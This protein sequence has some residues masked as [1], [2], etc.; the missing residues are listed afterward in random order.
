MEEYK[1]KY[2]NAVKGINTDSSENYQPD[3]TYRFALNV[4]N[5][6]EKDNEPFLSNENSNINVIDIPNIEVLGNIYVGDNENILFIVDIVTL[7][8][9]I[10][11]IKDNIVT[12]IIPLCSELHL[13]RFHRVT[14][15]F[16]KIRGCEK[17]IYF[18]DNYNKP[19]QLN[20]STLENYF[21]NNVLVSDRLNL[22]DDFSFPSFDIKVID[23]P[24]KLYAGSYSI[25][26]QYL[27]DDFNS[28]HWIHISNPVNVYNASTTTK[29]PKIIGSYTQQRKDSTYDALFS[30]AMCRK[31]IKIKINHTANN[32]KVFTYFR[33][34]IIIARADTGNITEVLASPT[35]SIIENEIIY[36]GNNEGYYKITKEE[37]LTEKVDIDTVKHIEQYDNRL[38][39]ANGKG[40][41]IDWCSFQKTASKIRSDYIIDT[42]KAHDVNTSNNPKSS[43]SIKM[44]FMGGDVYAFGIVYIFNDGTQSPTYH[45]PGKSS[46]GDS[47][48]EFYEVTSNV[49]E[50][51]PIASNADYWGQ[52]YWGNNLTGQK[53]RHHKFPDR[54]T[55]KLTNPYSGTG[56]K[57]FKFSVHLTFNETPS[58]FPIT[59]VITYFKNGI[60]LQK[61]ISLLL[62]EYSSSLLVFIDYGNITDDFILGAVSIELHDESSFTNFTT[63]SSIDSIDDPLYD[64][65]LNL[66]TI[67][68]SNIIYPSSD[69][70][71]HF[72]V[73]AKRDSNNRLIIDK[74]IV[75]SLNIDSNLPDKNKYITNFYF[76]NSQTYLNKD[77][78]IFY[79]KSPKILFN[80]D[81]LNPDSIKIEGAYRRNLSTYNDTLQ[82]NA[83]PGTSS[84]G[85]FFG[86]IKGD[87]DGM[88]WN[89][90]SKY[91]NYNFIRFDDL[92][93]S[94][95]L[96]E[97]QGDQICHISKSDYLRQGEKIYN[98][99]DNNYILVNMELD[100]QIAVYSSDNG[101]LPFSN[102]NDKKDDL[103]YVAFNSGINDIHPVLEDITY[104]KTHENMETGDTTTVSEG[105]IYINHFPLTHSTFYETDKP[106]RLGE[107]VSNIIALTIVAT[108][109]VILSIF[110]AGVGS[111]SIALV[112]A[113]GFSVLGEVV[114][115][116]AEILSEIIK[117]L[118]TG[119]LKGY[120]KNRD[121][122]NNT[123]LGNIKVDD[124]TMFYVGEHIENV[125]V[126]SDL[127]TE[128]RLKIQQKV[129]SFYDNDGF[130]GIPDYFRSK[131]LT[132]DDAR[133]DASLTL[134]PLGNSEIYEANKDYSRHSSEKVFFPIPL[135]YK[136]T[137][138]CLE[139]WNNRILWSERSF[140]EDRFDA[141]KVF[142]PNNYRDI[143]GDYGQITGLKTLNMNIFIFTE[144]MLFKIPA[145][146]QERV[147]TEFTTFIGTGEFLSLDPQK[148]AD[149]SIGLCGTTYTNSIYKF[150]NSILFIDDRVNKIY[151]ITS[152][153]LK[154]I[155]DKGMQKWFKEN[156]T[157][158]IDEIYKDT[159]SDKTSVYP[160]KEITNNP[161]GC[162]FSIIGDEKNNRF[163]ITKQ[164]M[165][166]KPIPDRLNFYFDETGNPNL[167]P[168][169][170]WLDDDRYLSDDYIYNNSFTISF[171]LN[172]Y[173]WTS[174]HSYLP[175]MYFRSD[176]NFYSIMQI[177]SI[178]K[179]GLDNSYGSFYGNNYDT[180]IDVILPLQNLT[181][182]IDEFLYIN[183]KGELYDIDTK[184][185]T[186]VRKEFFTSVIF[187]NSY[188][189]SG[190]KILNVKKESSDWLN[191]QV[192]NT[193]GSILVNKREGIF[194]LNE[195]RDYRIDY[196]KPI[197]TKNLLNLQ[198]I[199]YI[200]KVINSQTLDMNKSWYDLQP[201]R[202][203][204]LGI[205]LYHI[206]DNIKF[207]LYYIN[208]IKNISNV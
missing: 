178:W 85:Y 31:N 134:I 23:A 164:D 54:N 87:T 109:A 86:I 49:Y 94:N 8:S 66:L 59:I 71:G 30:Q 57:I 89:M 202:D 200:D 125:F 159:I 162:G 188:Q 22:I 60:S 114:G 167:G 163:I 179:H 95:T 106:R 102:L 185:Y 149:D 12:D 135:T 171:S 98:Y 90:S 104:Y 170:A 161:Q 16:R 195:I 136:C 198:N 45:I 93:Y 108:A 190:E 4:V 24:G 44:G 192:V 110:T 40:K 48:M 51:R 84:K 28:T 199:Y 189:C 5:N 183:T 80:K 124:D 76:N 58:N 26:I 132:N 197:F 91:I 146:I 205:R 68:F 139:K 118:D 36:T 138:N 160:L 133:D 141:Y 148:M 67:K 62:E 17:V 184:E 50:N 154:C 33:L 21:D 123:R 69:I 77:R 63:T 47:N 137:S 64:V 39:L 151:L 83:Y 112:I 116:S 29:Y 46:S 25:A 206:N 103:F 204:Y 173:S 128:L 194:D 166:I 96:P 169:N 144:R 158:K 11:M 176:D 38:L 3:N 175:Y 177:G 92:N 42:V 131:Y 7:K 19:R 61:N 157:F 82:E 208:S 115:V 2:T 180:I 127:N 196:N 143:P 18:T 126:E 37:I 130:Q 113:L 15:I 73:S 119:E 52:D 182:F 142:L 203:N 75:Q 34:A 107:T 168:M 72:I 111:E 121:L 145:N 41:Q 165:I 81:K 174:F 79:G 53:I 78:F 88:D 155:S 105:D 56:M 35:Y 10:K 152:E 14:G 9:G 13:N 100:S 97:Y 187:Y 20:L 147:T 129:S 193:I 117:D 201:F 120:I 191:K 6:T 207:K 172:T 150:Q 156:L 122:Q 99:N 27:N 1:N 65:T 32:T 153:G 74:G 140:T 55:I 181:E 101:G 70:V 186:V 43:T